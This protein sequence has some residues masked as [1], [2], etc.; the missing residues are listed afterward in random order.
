MSTY[1]RD[2]QWLATWPLNAETVLFY[3]ALSPYYDRAS[4]NELVR[5][6]QLTAD[7][8]RCVESRGGRKG[9]PAASRRL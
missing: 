8:T 6:Q 4:L 7:A 1:F 5:S 9:G 3:F 2:E